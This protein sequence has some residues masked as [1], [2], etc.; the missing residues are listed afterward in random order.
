M[1]L[2]S[3]FWRTFAQLFAPFV[4]AAV[5]A[6][7]VADYN[8]TV[9]QL[10]VGAVVALLGALAAV[11]A[12]IQ[13]GSAPTPAAK[14]VRSLVEAL[15]AGAATLTVTTVADIIALPKALWPML[16]G[17]VGA[18]VL[19]FFQNQGDPNAVTPRHTAEQV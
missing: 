8:V 13:W 6:A 10:L 1:S 12:A 19:T 17:A 5:T 16:L 7:Q 11:G 15:V 18:A 14:A 9:T 3:I 2:W 4:L